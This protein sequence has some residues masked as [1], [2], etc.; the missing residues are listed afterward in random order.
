MIVPSLL[1][2]GNGAAWQ[3]AVEALARWVDGKPAAQLFRINPLDVAQAQGL[4]ANVVV[5]A[6]LA[7]VLEG[8]FDLRWEFHCP[9]CQGIPN[10]TT[11]LSQA[12]AGGDCPMCQVSF[13]NELDTNVEVTF[14]A[15][16]KLA[17]FAEGEADA[18]LL[19]HHMTIKNGTFV[20]PENPLTGLDLMH[21]ALFRDRF[22]N[23][24]LSAEETLEIKHVVL[25]FTDIKGSTMLYEQLGDATAYN[26]VREHFKVL[27]RAIEAQGGVVVKTIGDAV[28]ASFRRPVD[29]LNSAL[30]LHH[31][32]DALKVPGTEDAVVVK[33]GLHAGPAIAVTMNER[34]DYFGQTVNKA[35]RIQGL[36]RDQEIYFSEPVFQDAECRRSLATRKAA[37]RRWRTQLKGI[38]GDQIVYSVK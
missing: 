27:F 28:M 20:K 26:L 36:A 19:A 10:F 32:I 13:R 5:D 30:S 7:G 22:S 33:M 23:D 15:A 12:K 35:A 4:E 18:L 25:L 9:H 8:W 2:Y 11:H 1:P 37:V 6:F 38:E 21:R 17:Q 24:V 16:P 3:P 34:F 29:A 31:E 14:T